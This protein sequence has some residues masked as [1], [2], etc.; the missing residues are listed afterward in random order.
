M[1]RRLGWLWTALVLLACFAYQWLVHSAVVEE[2]SESIRV[3]LMLLPLLALAYWIA[4]RSRH[5][6]LWLLILLA[7]AGAI[8]L[9]E[10]LER[11]GLVA[12]YGLS[13]IAAYLFLLWLFGRTLAR[14]KEPLVTR[15]A[16]RVHGALQPEMDR[17]TRRLTAAWCVFFA[18][19]VV[20]SA[21]LFMFSSL[22]T[23][24]LFIN[25]LNFPLVVVM[26]VSE[27]VYRV[28]RH[29]NFPHASILKSFQAFAKDAALSKNAEVR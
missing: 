18:A 25:L 5:K 6:L 1:K 11:W 3:A 4:T 12:A 23:W 17:Y 20:A 9:L 10:H 16:R 29:R 26:F 19:Q 8:Y 24:S 7:A 28:A 27:Y 13:H 14:G 21:L 2:Q 22:D 15:L